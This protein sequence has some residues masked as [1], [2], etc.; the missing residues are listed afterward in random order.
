V[1]DLEPYQL[2]L[3]GLTL[4][5]GTA[6]E[7]SGPIDGL[8][9]LDPN[10]VDRGLHPDDGVAPGDDTYPARSL[11]IP[12]SVTGDGAAGVMGALRALRGAF[13]RDTTGGLDELELCLPGLTGTGNETLT[14]FG[15]ARGAREKL[16][17]L[18]NGEAEALARFDATD[19]LGYATAVTAWDDPAP[20]AD[21][22]I[23]IT[24]GGDFPTRRAVFEI[25]G[26]GDI[27]V[28]TNHD[29]GDRYLAWTNSLA[30][31]AIRIIDFAARTVIDA[32]GADHYPEIA[33]GSPWF[34]FWP[35]AQDLQI[36]GA[37]TVE[38]TLR[39]AYT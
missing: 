29:D 39:P 21:A 5:A 16:D 23:T 28:I 37:G 33:A 9:A 7:L 11:M 24:P 6:Y 2:R 4:G 36:V 19:P 25:T 1:A 13:G 18:K 26:T 3:R 27:P 22:S 34:V 30:A 12:L 14:Y 15:R 32:A 38:L 31:G 17:D 35:T 10:T 8:G 20:G